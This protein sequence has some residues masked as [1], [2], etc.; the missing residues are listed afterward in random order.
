MRRGAGGGRRPEARQLRLL[1][2]YP[3]LESRQDVHVIRAAG[4]RPDRTAWRVVRA[5][6]LPPGSRATCARLPTGAAYHDLPKT[7]GL[8]P[9]ASSFIACLGSVLR[10]ATLRESFACSYCPYDSANESCQAFYV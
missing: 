5:D 7:A 4:R 9:A 6:S 1:R 8:C 10:A 2:R 3:T